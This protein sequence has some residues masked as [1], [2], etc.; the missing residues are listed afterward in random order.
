MLICIEDELE[1]IRKFVA[2]N[3]LLENQDFLCQYRERKK[4]TI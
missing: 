1:P 3:F 4:K 2:G